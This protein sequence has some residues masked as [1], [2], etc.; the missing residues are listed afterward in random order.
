MEIKA[1]LD[2][3]QFPET[4]FFSATPSVTTILRLVFRKVKSAQLSSFIIKN[5]DNQSGIVFDV[6]DTESFSVEKVKFPGI[7]NLV[8]ANSCR[9]DYGEVPCDQ[10]F[11]HKDEGPDSSMVIMMAVIVAF[12]GE[13]TLFINQSNDFIS[14]WFSFTLFQS[15]PGLLI[16]S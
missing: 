11:H 16:Y 5:F 2:F 3:M 8:H 7:E 9:S 4:L 6:K 1:N 15:I 12:T 13:I 10:V 14:D